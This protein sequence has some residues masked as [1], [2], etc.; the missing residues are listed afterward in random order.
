MERNIP[1]KWLNM[2]VTNIHSKAKKKVIINVKVGEYYCNI[3]NRGLIGPEAVLETHVNGKKHLRLVIL[4]VLWAL[5]KGIG[6]LSGIV[7]LAS[8]KKS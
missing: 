6:S 1:N 8:M 5:L 3:C 4:G 7:K 2:Y